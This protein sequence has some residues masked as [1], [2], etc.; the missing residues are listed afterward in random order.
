MDSQEQRAESDTADSKC[1]N[2]VGLCHNE[3]SLV[4]RTMQEALKL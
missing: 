2:L 1:I 4:D 3:S